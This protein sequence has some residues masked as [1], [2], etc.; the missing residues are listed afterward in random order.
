MVSA[1]SQPCSHAAG[2]GVAA[3]AD[4]GDAQHG[5]GQVEP[6]VGEVLGAV[7]RHAEPDADPGDQGDRAR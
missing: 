4:G 1:D 2:E 3:E 6:V 5:A 7:G